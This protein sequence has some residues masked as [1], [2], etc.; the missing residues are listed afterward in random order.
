M[1]QNKYLN[2]DPAD[3]TGTRKADTLEIVLDVPFWPA[4]VKAQIKATRPAPATA[5][6]CSPFA[7]CSAVFAGGSEFLA[8]VQELNGAHFDVQ[9][10][11]LVAF[12]DRSGVVVEQWQ[13]RGFLAAR[14]MMHSHFMPAFRLTRREGSALKISKTFL[15]NTAK[16]E[17]SDGRTFTLTTSTKPSRAWLQMRSTNLS[18]ITGVVWE[19]EGRYTVCDYDSKN[20]LCNTQIYSDLYDAAY[21]L[22]HSFAKDL[23]APPPKDWNTIYAALDERHMYARRVGEKLAS[24]GFMMDSKGVRHYNNGVSILPNG[25]V[26]YPPNVQ[27]LTFEN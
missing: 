9:E 3:V 23:D 2:I 16:A 8:I 4:V 17:F 21:H 11:V 1:A 15:G 22:Q 27:P 6:A 24:V 18:G 20:R 26:Q 7:F 5:D 14:E 12:A 13:T 25:Q 10:P 19:V